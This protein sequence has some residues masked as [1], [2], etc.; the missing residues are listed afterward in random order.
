MSFTV[1]VADAAA[2]RRALAQVAE[3]GGV[4]SVRRR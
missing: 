1:E 4:L 3:V 2:L